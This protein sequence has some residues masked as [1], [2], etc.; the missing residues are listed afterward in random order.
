MKQES[1]NMSLYSEVQV[2][3]AGGFVG[4]GGGGGGD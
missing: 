2:E 1:L 3:H 4:R